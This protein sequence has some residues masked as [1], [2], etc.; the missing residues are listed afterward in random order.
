[1]TPVQL[2]VSGLHNTI[3]P[4]DLGQSNMNAYGID[5]EGPLPSARYNG[6][7]WRDIAMKVPQ[8]VCPVSEA[9]FNHLRSIIN[10]LTASS[11]YGIDLYV[12]TVQIVE[13]ISQ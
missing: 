6:E 2:W 5:F 11:C 4:N 12:R 3:T 8:I 1:M 9:Q 13:N 10:P 7:T